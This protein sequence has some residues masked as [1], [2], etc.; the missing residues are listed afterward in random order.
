MD[1]GDS[2]WPLVMEDRNRSQVSQCEICGCRSVPGTGFPPSISV[3]PSQYH[4]T[5]A[6]NSSSSAFRSYRNDILV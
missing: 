4:F 1:Q 5:N 2:H 3:L 6:S